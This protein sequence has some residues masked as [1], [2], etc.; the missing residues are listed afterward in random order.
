MS[1]LFSDAARERTATVAPLAMRVR[2]A[3]LDEFVGQRHVCKLYQGDLLPVQAS[4][5]GQNL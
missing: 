3:T 2:P 1:D 5:G 4:L